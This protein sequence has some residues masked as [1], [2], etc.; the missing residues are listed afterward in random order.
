[1]VLLRRPQRSSTDL[2]S[3]WTRTF[4]QALVADGVT[5]EPQDRLRAAGAALTVVQAAPIAFDGSPVDAP[6]VT[7]QDP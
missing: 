3:G 2:P 7:T 5:H 6:P 4:V 1:M